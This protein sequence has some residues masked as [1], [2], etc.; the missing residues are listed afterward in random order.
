MRKIFILFL[1]MKCFLIGNAQPAKVTVNIKGGVQ[2]QYLKSRIESNAGQLLSTIN[3]DYLRS[4]T[5]LTIDDRIITNAAKTA[6]N[7]LWSDVKYYCAVDIID[8]NLLISGQFY[9]LRN[10]PIVLGDKVQN[11]VIN[12]TNDGKIDDFYFGLELH[13]YQNV[14]NPNSVVDKTRREI[15]LNFIENFR[16][17]YVRKDIEFIEKVFSEHA[18]IITGRVVQQ[19]SISTDNMKSSLSKRQIEYLVHTKAEYVERLR[20]VFKNI[21]HLSLNFND[22]EV[23]VHRK[24]SNFYGV[25]LEQHWATANYQ[26]T[27][28]LFLV[29]QF[30]DDDHPLIWIRT[31]QDASEFE[32]NEIFGFHN[33]RIA[34]GAVR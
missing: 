32:R 4:K 31:W 16:T 33:F 15:I 27:G 17:A 21:S 22:I 7:E 29:I 6:M 28:Y 11:V 12:F 19:H 9:Q 20:N 13:Q 1:L 24:Y 10:I 2:D 3:S 8:E 34:E 26:D 5:E 25:L 30:R 18:L 14:M 23:N